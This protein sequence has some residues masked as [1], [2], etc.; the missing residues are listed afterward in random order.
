[1]EVA[2]RTYQRF[3]DFIGSESRIPIGRGFSEGQPYCPELNNIEH[4]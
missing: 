2:E 3:I 4:I 1:M